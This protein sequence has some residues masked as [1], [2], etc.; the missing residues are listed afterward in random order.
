MSTDYYKILELDKTDDQSKIK[1][2]Y[3]RLALKWHPDKNNSPNASD[4]F[5]KINEAYT[6]LG[7]PE[8]KKI[9]DETGKTDI[10]MNAQ[11][12]QNFSNLFNVFNG[13]MFS[14]NNFQFHQSF[15]NEQ[16]INVKE[17]KI[18]YE[19]IDTYFGKHIEKNIS[20]ELP[21]FHC[22]HSGLSPKCASKIKCECCG[23]NGRIRKKVQMFN[24]I[25]ETIMLCN[26]CGGLGIKKSCM[27]EKCF[28]KK[29]LTEKKLISYD[30][31]PGYINGDKIILKNSGDYNPSTNSYGDLIL[32]IVFEKTTLYDKY[33]QDISI[34]NKKLGKYDLAKLYSISLVDSICGFSVS[35]EHLNKHIVSFSINEIIKNEQSFIV[36]GEGLPNQQ[37]ECGDLYVIFVIDY[38]IQ[39]SNE[40]KQSIKKIFNNS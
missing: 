33:F 12:F 34:G 21:C 31:K 36:K 19:F 1:Q 23:G 26:E 40:Q 9:Y 5:K 29:T 4:M 17:L 30:L 8:R 16:P 2:A 15:G 38:S 11:Q 22:N 32:T 39:L 28:G 10:N 37:N 14:N 25:T 3:K 18:N 24:L 35:F 6:I 27:C 13:N 20:L 7:D